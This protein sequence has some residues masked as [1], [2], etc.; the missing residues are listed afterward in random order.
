[1]NMEDVEKWVLVIASEYC[2]HPMIISWGLY[3]FKIFLTI[4]ER[5]SAL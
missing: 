5:L 3:Y 4:S 1:M 2:L